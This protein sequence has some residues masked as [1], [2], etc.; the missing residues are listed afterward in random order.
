MPCTAQMASVM[1]RISKSWVTESDVGAVELAAAEEVEEPG[2]EGDHPGGDEHADGEEAGDAAADGGGEV[3]GCASA[4]RA[5][6]KKGREAAP[7]AGPMT[8]KGALKRSLALPMRV[9]PP[10][11]DGGEVVEEEAVEHDERDADH[12]GEGELEPLEEGG[13]SEVEDGAEVEAGAEGADG[14]EQE[15]AADDAGEDADGEGVDADLAVE[16]EGAEDDAEVV[17][18]RGCRPGR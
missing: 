18:Q 12:E 3:E 14:V 6:A 13:V 1:E 5:M 10:V 16:E 9:M 2:G 8:L 4:G 15:G 17:D 7:A 11:G